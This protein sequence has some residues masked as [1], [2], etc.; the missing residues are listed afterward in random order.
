MLL[1]E[2]ARSTELEQKLD[3]RDGHI[4]GL[5]RM[6]AKLRRM[7]FG[8]SSEK[9]HQQ[10]EQ[11]KFE[12]EE[13]PQAVCRKLTSSGPNLWCAALDQSSRH[14]PRKVYQFISLTYPRI[15]YR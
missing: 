15:F 9:L 3:A 6:L 10:I 8:R 7:P 11:R 1:A 5:E 13:R 12:L 4:E 2:C 14:Q